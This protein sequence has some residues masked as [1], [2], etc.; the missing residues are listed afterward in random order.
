LGSDEKVLSEVRGSTPH[1]G[2]YNILVG[3]VDGTLS[4]RLS[5]C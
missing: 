2:L 5:V 3:L 1:G 4:V